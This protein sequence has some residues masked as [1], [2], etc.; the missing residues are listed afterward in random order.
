M[1]YEQ[2]VKH[3]D[4]PVKTDNGIGI[5]LGKKTDSNGLYFEK[6]RTQWHV[7]YGVDN[8]SRGVWL[9]RSGY[10]HRDLQPLTSSETKKFFAAL[11]EKTRRM[12]QD[13][14]EVL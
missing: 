5:L 2:A 4:K 13:P 10:H 1:T 11:P 6:C 14:A 8:S 7:W 9:S 12:I 3:I